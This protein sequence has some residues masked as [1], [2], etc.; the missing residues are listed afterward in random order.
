M[1]A[2]G[3]WVKGSLIGRAVRALG[4]A[5]KKTGDEM[6]RC[7]E[8]KYNIQCMLNVH[9]TPGDRRQCD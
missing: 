8:G 6:L 4:G 7:F 9:G 1:V 3:R 5:D 2:P